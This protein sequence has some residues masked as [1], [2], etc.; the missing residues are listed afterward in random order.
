MEYLSLKI[1]DDFAMQPVNA[2]SFQQ[3]ISMHTVMQP[4]IFIV[5]SDHTMR[6]Q[7]IAPH[8]ATK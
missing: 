5:I 4:V 1:K 6:Y 8:Q 7:A 2:E 3:L